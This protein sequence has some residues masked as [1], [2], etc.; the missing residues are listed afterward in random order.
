MTESDSITPSFVFGPGDTRM[1]IAS[2]DRLLLG[3][4]DTAGQ[5]S[6]ITGTIEG[7]EGPPLHTHGGD[8]LTWII[9]GGPLTIQVGDDITEVEPGGGY[10]AKAGTPHTFANCTN[11]P[12]RYVSVMAPGGFEHFLDESARY[13]A[14]LAGED[15]DPARIAE[16]ADRYDSTPVGPPLAAVLPQLPR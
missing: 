14:G 10:W 13:F 11:D 9:S 16:M 3:A 2:G 4:A 7:I 15:P 5:L 8:E 12:V 6:V 1:R